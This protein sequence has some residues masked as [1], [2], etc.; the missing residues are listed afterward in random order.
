MI[1]VYS[2]VYNNTHTTESNYYFLINNYAGKSYARVAYE[3]IDDYMYYHSSYIVN[4]NFPLRNR[5]KIEIETIKYVPFV[6]ENVKQKRKLSIVTKFI[7][8]LIVKNNI[9]NVPKSINSITYDINGDSVILSPNAFIKSYYK[10][11]PFF[12]QIYNQ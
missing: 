2:K 7:F 11:V 1:K 8:F 5:G 9:I 10:L 3:L 4:F 12:E 6:I